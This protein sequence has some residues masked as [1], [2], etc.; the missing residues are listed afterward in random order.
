[1]GGDEGTRR[2]V[3]DVPNTGVA[4]MG[5]ID[6]DAEEFH[7]MEEF[8]AELR[9]TVRGVRDGGIVRAWRAGVWRGERVLEIPCER[10]DADAEAVEIPQCG[11]GALAA[12]AVFN[13]QQGAD[14]AGRAIGLQIRPRFHLRDLVWIFIEYAVELIDFLHGI[15]QWVLVVFHI[16]ERGEALQ[17]II[18]FRKFLQINLVVVLF[19]TERGAFP[20]GLA[21]FVEDVAMEINDFHRMLLLGLCKLPPHYNLYSKGTLASF[22]ENHLIWFNYMSQKTI[23][24]LSLHEN[25]SKYCIFA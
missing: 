25:E 9:Q 22:D 18:A 12:A 1:M 11:E 10:H 13:G 17:K 15:Q 24:L 2:V 7:F 21:C 4:Q 5:D 19:E 3:I 8:D 20:G 6:D 16:D 14:L 23:M